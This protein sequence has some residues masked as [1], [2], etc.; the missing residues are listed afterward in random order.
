MLAELVEDIE[1]ELLPTRRELQLFND[2]YEAWV[3]FRRY[4]MPY[5][6]GSLEQPENWLLMMDCVH[7]A[8][9]EADYK[10]AEEEEMTRRFSRE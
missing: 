10:L 5:A 3:S 1:L 8:K 6:G 7:R 9:A 2:I 4:G